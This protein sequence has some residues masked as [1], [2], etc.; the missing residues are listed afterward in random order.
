M[1]M[2]RRPK[3]VPRNAIEPVYAG[4]III[5]RRESADQ[6][7]LLKSLG[8]EVGRYNS[9]ARSFECCRATLSAL[10]LLDPYWGTFI[11]SLHK[12]DN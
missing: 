3:R 11:W 7:G 4:C 9:A 5:D 10:K 8:I 2:S 6:E 12:V 1:R